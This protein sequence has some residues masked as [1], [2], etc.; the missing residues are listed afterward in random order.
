MKLERK[1]ME[2]LKT[3]GFFFSS[4]SIFKRKARGKEEREERERKRSIQNVLAWRGLLGEVEQL[5]DLCEE[6]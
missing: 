5:F 6:N 4:F 2:R 1:P 3:S